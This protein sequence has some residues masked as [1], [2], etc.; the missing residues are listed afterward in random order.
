MKNSILIIFLL[1]ILL[2]ACT[3]KAKC[4]TERRTFYD[5]RF[6]IDLP[7]AWM[8]IKDL[9]HGFEDD[10]LK[11]DK[12]IGEKDFQSGVEL[13]VHH[14]KKL[15]S[16]AMKNILA[17]RIAIQRISQTTTQ[18]IDS[19][20]VKLNG[21][22]AGRFNYYFYSGNNKCYGATVLLLEDND[23]FIANFYSLKKY[24]EDFVKICS[25]SIRS[26]RITN[27]STSNL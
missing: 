2:N 3:E 17:R 22:E 8:L 7:E 6:S 9:Q 4:R 11:Y 18:I 23:L 20:I 13:E 1:L 16:I 25:Q 19:C 26:I 15:K 5:N 12:F 10:G 14:E 21:I 24:N 27:D